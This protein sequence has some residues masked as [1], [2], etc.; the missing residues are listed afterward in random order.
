MRRHWTKAALCALAFALAAPALPAQASPPGP[1]AP[2][3]A[4]PD[5][6]TVDPAKRDEL[7]G[8]G[9]QASGDRLW[10]TTSD[11]AGLHLLVADA[12]NGYS[13]RTA[14]TLVEP[15]LDADEWIGNVC[16]T[17]SGKR[18]V[19]VYAPRTFTNDAAL[20]NRGGF[21]A[22]V[23]LDSGVVTKLAVHTTLAYY[24]PGCGTG[25]TAMLT[26]EGDEQLGKTGVLAVDAATG[27]VGART[28]LAGQV[29]SPV[30]VKDG[31]VVADTLGL[32][33]VANSGRRTRLV[34]GT[35][36]VPSHVRP[37][38]EGGVVYMDRDG[39][40]SRV[41]R[42]QPD[43][44]NAVTLATGA[45][46]DLD[47][48]SGAAGKVFI[49]GKAAKVQSLPATVTK[50]DLPVGAAVSSHGDTAVTD[51][52]FMPNQDAHARPDP[53]KP[54][55]VHIQSKSLRTGRQ[56]GFTV[57]PG[58]TLTPR[59][60]DP[61]DAGEVCSVPRND[62]GV[63]VYQPI[64]KQVEWAA[65]NAVRGTLTG[66]RHT[67]LNPQAM[68]PR[69]GLSTG[70]QVP[71]QI[72]LGVMGQESNLWEADR[73]TLPGE[74]GNPLIGNYY[75]INVLDSSDQWTI[76][77]AN[78]DCGYGVT[79]MTDGMRL[80]GHT[81]TGETALPPIQ[82]VGIGMHFAVNVAAGLRLLEQKWN[83]L[84]A[85]GM[86][87]NDND[88]SKIENW[89]Y[90]TWAYN[91][92]LHPAG[93]SGANNGAWGLGW[94]NNPINPRYDPNR[95]NFGSDPH[96]FAHPQLWPYPE[97]VLGFASNPPA[98]VESPGV[99]A[100]FFR[101]AWWG[102]N[103]G[104]ETVPGSAKYNRKTAVPP[105][106]AFCNATDNCDVNHPAD[107]N[108]PAGPCAHRDTNGALDQECW[109]HVPVTW[110]SDCASTCG[111]E[112]VRYDA[113][114]AEAVDGT[115]YPP[116]CDSTGLAQQAAVVDDVSTAT[117]PVRDPNCN[118]IKVN[119]GTFG[120]TFANDVSRIDLHQIG[121]GYGA[122]FWSSHTNVDGALGNRLKI[123]GTWAFDPVVDGLARV[124]VFLP[125]HL[126]SSTT[127]VG[128]VN[129]VIDTANGPKTVKLNQLGGGDR[130]IDLGIYPFFGKPAIHLS[131]IVDAGQQDKDVVWDAAAIEP[132][133]G[134]D[135]FGFQP[136]IKDISSGCLMPKNNSSANN[137]II[138]LRECSSLWAANF[139]QLKQ[140]G[141]TATP[142]GAVPVFQIQDRGNSNCLDMVGESKAVGALAHEAACDTT[143]ASQQWYGM[144][145]Q[146]ATSTDTE[147][148]LINMNSKMCL[149]PTVDGLGAEQ[150]TCTDQGALQLWSFTMS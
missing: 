35:G 3:A 145:G 50:V 53:T 87:L 48:V 68:F 5:L 58:A 122:H 111:H 105:H 57:D 102:G 121:G 42:A 32:L 41:Q 31:F 70:G 1:A 55:P 85:A 109:I 77:W 30:P 141:T 129:Y 36:G 52:S 4:Q 139:W 80:A 14:A 72:L 89:F 125:A 115:S 18:A 150:N 8:Q 123:T 88:P 90:A 12:R 40:N 73:Y 149:E 17:G 67:S 15:G 28:E 94:L 63:Q 56:L 101:A 103:N 107:P 54:M 104:D 131:T 33:K 13:W 60:D 138:A 127:N 117:K 65:D 143:K 64:P 2:T 98:G 22:V 132:L 144:L 146:N 83:E 39:P 96:D 47:V 110:K 84:Q 69:A 137:A 106:D 108:G 95:H 46:G 93:Q 135:H 10:T 74:Y 49:T 75:G 128:T 9:W 119:S 24:N 92:G 134:E 71:S 130:W 26:Q 148:H 51:V 82:Q 100:P 113:G 112:F 59:W 118:G 133:A 7:L 76:N 86:Q 97:K 136:L 142:A 19:A 44:A 114:V 11:S 62:T 61:K 21:T 38:A 37:D 81:K 6:P 116:K 45:V 23:D 27:K 16:L 29:T 91:S 25:E 126:D 140:V 79:Q 120:F 20:A 124:K 78:A 99:T 66:E 147:Q 34:G 43:T